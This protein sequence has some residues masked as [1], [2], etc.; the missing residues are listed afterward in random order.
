MGLTVLRFCFAHGITMAVGPRPTERI[1][2]SRLSCIL[3][4]R[5]FH[6]GITE[7][8]DWGVWRFVTRVIHELKTRK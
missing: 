3:H 7:S 2:P 6:G 1:A 8:T 4:L 5:C